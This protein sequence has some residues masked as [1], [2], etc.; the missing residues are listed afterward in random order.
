M[1]FIPLLP[2]KLWAS[3]LLLFGRQPDRPLIG[4]LDPGSPLLVNT[5]TKRIYVEEQPEG[6]RSDSPAVL[7]RAFL[8]YGD[9]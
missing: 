3:L 6:W 9:I 4:T 2:V 5:V 1:A 8:L 7:R